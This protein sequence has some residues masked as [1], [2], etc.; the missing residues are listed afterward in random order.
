V[1]AVE[2]QVG[3]LLEL[4]RTVI[5]EDL[6]GAYLHGSSVL[7]GLRPDSDVDLLAV[8]ARGTTSDEKRH[9]VDA[10]LAI[11]GTDPP[12]R[13]PVELD[14]VI[15]SEIRPWRYPPT[16]DF[17]YDELLR[18]EFEKGELEPWPE[19][20]NVDL[21]SVVTMVLLGNS[22][23]FGPPPQE[24]L[25]PVPREDYLR[26]ILRDTRTVDEYLDWD[27]RNVILTLARIWSAV[28]TT[29][30]MSKEDAASWALP[31]LPQQHR[32]VLERARAAYRGDLDDGSWNDLLPQA[33]AYSSHVVS[34]IERTR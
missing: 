18:E 20:T 34:Q 2:A 11:S 27:T 33:R 15:A 32:R 7:G 26:A 28:A 13:R 30:I 31:R 10:L 5:G 1:A 14:I 25:G 17:H 23:L 21:A 19:L 29:E 6:L 8:A 9:L 16:F 4:L 22:A 24:L 3:E 12:A